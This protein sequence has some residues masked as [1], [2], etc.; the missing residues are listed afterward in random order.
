MI[1]LQLQGAA[2]MVD[3]HGGRSKPLR[4]FYPNRDA[5]QCREAEWRASGRNTPVD[6]ELKFWLAST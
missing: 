3:R 2:S 6:Q 1:V 4:H 5:R